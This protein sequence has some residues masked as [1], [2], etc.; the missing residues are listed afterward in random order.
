MARIVEVKPESLTS[1]VEPPMSIESRTELRPLYDALVYTGAKW[2]AWLWWSISGGIAGALGGGL[3]ALVPGGGVWVIPLVLILFIA[4]TKLHRL[5]ERECTA[6]SIQATILFPVCFWMAFIVPLHTLSLQ[7]SSFSAALV[8]GG[9]AVLACLHAVTL[10]CRVRH[11]SL[12]VCTGITCGAVAA[13]A[14]VLGP[15]LASMPL[16]NLQSNIADGALV[17]FLYSA[18]S[19]AALI[20]LFWDVSVIFAQLAYLLEQKEHLPEAIAMYDLALSNRPDD[21]ELY[22]NRGTIYTRLGEHSQA[23][24]DFDKALSLNANYAPAYSNRASAY[25]DVDDYASAIEDYD[26]AVSIDPKDAVTLNS[27]GNLHAS[28]GDLTLALADFDRSI[29]L[30]PTDPMVYSNRGAAYSRLGDVRRAIED[31]GSAIKLNPD[32]ANSYANRA[33]AYYKIGEYEKG[34]AD[35]DRGLALRPDHA[36]TYSNRG[37]CRAALGDTERAASDFRRALELPC[38]PVVREEALDGLRA[39][40]LEP[41]ALKAEVKTDTSNDESWSKRIDSLNVSKKSY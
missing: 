13:V 18:L 20:W 21:V 8:I 34:I 11:F 15:R 30:D 5:L 9:V 1:Q 16:G 29:A 2:R 35:C 28:L 23:I 36:A 41:D 7:S 6:Q 10:G 22:F 40:G 19:S 33:F 17:G 24:E 3:S 37:L 31:Y 25:L 4:V 26:K 38:P 32:Y 12:W 39:L 14:G 27:R